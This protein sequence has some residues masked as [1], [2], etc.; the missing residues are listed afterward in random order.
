MKQLKSLILLPLVGV[1]L[2]GMM[3][4]EKNTPGIDQVSGDEIVFKRLSF[5]SDA[6]FYEAL[7]QFSDTEDHSF[8]YVEDIRPWEEE[9][10]FVSMR[11]QYEALFA[12]FENLTSEQEIIRFAEEHAELVTFSEGAYQMNP[13]LSFGLMNLLAPDATVVIADALYKYTATHIYIII[14]KDEAKLERA[15]ATGKMDVENGI[16]VI[17]DWRKTE[18]EFRTCNSTTRTRACTAPEVN[19][20]RVRGFWEVQL[21]A[22]PSRNQ[23]GQVTGWTISYFWD[24]RIEGQRRNIF[25]NWRSNQTRLGFT[26][27]FGVFSA[28]F[29]TTNTGTGWTVGSD[30][31]SIDH[32]F[33]VQGPAFSPGI[34]LP[35]GIDNF[36]ITYCTCGA[37][38]GNIPPSGNNGGVFCY[39]CCP[40]DCSDLDWSDIN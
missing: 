18:L 6:D 40:W 36:S 8:S 19:D 4:C 5:D 25:N 24:I 22:V 23:F 21:G 15:L 9:Q 7:T 12:E 16:Y 26:S 33:R 10:G 14:D 29:G 35:A 13:P 2:L 27:G 11:R 3:S 39:Q 28:L 38:D 31:S 32:N 34:Q 20:R 17:P 30:V 37:K 1:F